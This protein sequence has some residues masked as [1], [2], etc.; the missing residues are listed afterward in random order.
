MD[1]G[2]P[3]SINGYWYLN[4]AISL[5]SQDK[6][7]LKRMTGELYPF[8]AQEFHT[9]PSKVERSMRYAIATS[10]NNCES[11][12]LEEIFGRTPGLKRGHVTNKQFIAILAEQINE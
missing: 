8:I 1:L 7:A 2:I 6:N 5:S 4:A 11:D 12:Y 3:P 9:T 10:F